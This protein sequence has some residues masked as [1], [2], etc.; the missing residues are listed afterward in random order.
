MEQIYG[1]MRTRR[2]LQEGVPG[3]DPASQEL[4]LQR[5]GV[6]LNNIHRDMVISGTTGTQERRDWHRLKGRMAGGTP[7]W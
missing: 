3:V 2:R 4:Q 1:Y 6:P 5:A 7:W